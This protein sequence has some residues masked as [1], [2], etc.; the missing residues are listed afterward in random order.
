M[1]RSTLILGVNFRRGMHLDV[2]T[3][4]TRLAVQPSPLYKSNGKKADDSPYFCILPSDWPKWSYSSTQS[5]SMM[6]MHKVFKLPERKTLKTEN[7]NQKR[8]HAMDR[9]IEK[10]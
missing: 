9:K 5:S 4:S 2:L 6:L 7:Q 1:D 3:F 8:L 10:A